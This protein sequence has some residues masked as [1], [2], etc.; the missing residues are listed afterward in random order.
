MPLETRC[1]YARRG[2]GVEDAAAGATEAANGLATA[3]S[4]PV[5]LAR[6]V[7]VDIAPEEDV[8]VAGDGPWGEPEDVLL[9]KPANQE[10]IRIA[11]ALDQLS[12]FGHEIAYGSSLHPLRRGRVRPR[13]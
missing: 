9:S 3:T 1:G 11:R 8:S 6:L 5:S 10:Q 7:N 12:L 2:L 13:E 4:V